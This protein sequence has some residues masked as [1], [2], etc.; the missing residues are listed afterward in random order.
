MELKKDWTTQDLYRPYQDWAPDYL[1]NLTKTV[2]NSPWRFGYHIQPPTGLLNDPNGF[3]YYNGKWQLFYQ[4]YPMGPV[5][6]VKSWA[7]VTS[8]NLVDW[9]EEGLKLL[10]D[11]SYDSHGVYSG[12]AMPMGDQLFLAY[13]GNVR[14][15]NW[16]RYTYQ[17]GAFMNPSGEITKI[18]TPLIAEP[19]KGYTTHFRDPQVFPFEDGYLMVI[20]AQN[21]QEE[22]EVLTY[23]SHDCLNWE[24]LGKLNF[25]NE[26][27]GFMAECPNLLLTDEHALLIFCPQGLDP[28]ICAYQNI[29]PNMY[30]TAASYDKEKNALISPSALKN[31][32]EGFDVYATQAFKAPDGRLLSVSW[33]GLP[34]IAYPTDK[35]GW[36]HGL[37]IVKELS[38][39]EDVLYQTPVKEMRELRQENATT[40]TDEKLVTF[41]AKSNQYELQIDFET[42]ASGT[43]TLLADEEQNHGMTIT[44]DASHGKMKID[45]SQAGEV[46][47]EDFGTSRAFEIANEPLSLQIFVDQSIIEIFINGG[48]EVATLRAF[49]TEKQ[50]QVHLQADAPFTTHFWPLRKMK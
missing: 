20:G 43:F 11:S 31:L 23:F 34:E 27:M 21:E 42:L 46:F 10:P 32:D 48:K 39:K 37:S 8:D 5:H 13:T 49:P 4:A 16:E 18:P 7:H 15:E 45:R 26:Q 6:G 47:G 40:Y 33:V 25:T 1:E 41:D 44:F 3:A 19:P 22:G 35:Y 2:K 30:V 17:M 14:D 36:A 24:Q 28:A 38:F 12:T 50:T 29:Y 9:Q